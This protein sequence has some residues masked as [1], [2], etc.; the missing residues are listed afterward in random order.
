MDRLWAPWRMEYILSTQ[1]EDQKCIFCEK[2]KETT[3]KANLIVYRSEYSFVIMNKY[4]Y[5]NGHVMVVPYVH[6]S[7]Y[8]DLSDEILMDMQHVLQLSIRVLNDTMRPHGLN[9]GL[10]L[11]R[12]A[13]AGIDEHLHYHLVPRWNGDTNFMPV[14][15]GTK[16]VSESLKDS[17]EKLHLSFKKITS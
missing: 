13:G 12:T 6:K 1:E 8:L 15:N 17:W 10:N 16:V 14:L 9:I 7:N 11:G 4:P 2:P 3:D 5:N